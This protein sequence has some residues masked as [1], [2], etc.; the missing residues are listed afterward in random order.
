MAALTIIDGGRV[1]RELVGETTLG[2]LERRVGAADLATMR[3]VR[4]DWSDHGQIEL[5]LGGRAFVARIDLDGRGIRL[6]DPFSRMPL[7]VFR[8]ARRGRGTV[9]FSDGSAARWIVP[10]RFSFECGFVSRNGA[11]LVRFAHDG[12]AIMIVDEVDHEQGRAPDPMVML[13]LGWLLRWVVAGGRGRSAGPRD[14][15]ARAS[16]SSESGPATSPV[17]D[18]GR[19][20]AA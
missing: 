18:P 7:A 8:P 2:A 4:S 9:V 19:A 17:R 20:S 16:R 6:S 3:G 11:N 12:T 15:V 5:T 13:V 10:D 14:G 1:V